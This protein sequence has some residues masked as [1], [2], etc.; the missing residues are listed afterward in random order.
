MSIHPRREQRHEH[1]ANHIRT[2]A[3]R[4]REL[5]HRPYWSRSRASRHRDCGTTRQPVFH[6]SASN[7]KH[8]SQHSV[9]PG[10]HH[11]VPQSQPYRAAPNFEQV[12]CGAVFQPPVVKYLMTV[13]FPFRRAAI[14]SHPRRSR[15]LSVRVAIMR[16]I[17][18]E[19][20]NA[21]CQHRDGERVEKGAVPDPW[22]LLANTIEGSKRCLL[23][24]P[25]SARSP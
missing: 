4:A 16:R 7:P 13:A 1:S 2:T 9:P 8:P 6:S 5:N 11:R 10:V 12:K 25:H 19:P 21:S 22:N 17:A 14:V 24:P 3:Y 18:G 23:T 15:H 20:V